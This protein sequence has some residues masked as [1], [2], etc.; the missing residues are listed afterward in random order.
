MK[1]LDKKSEKLKNILTNLKHFHFDFYHLFDILKLLK[2]KL[3]GATLPVQRQQI[4][5]SN[6]NFIKKTSVDNYFHPL[7]R[8]FIDKFQIGKLY[9]LF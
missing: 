3:V 2:Y 4:K 5:P 8:F 7:L 9:L 1:R 6:L